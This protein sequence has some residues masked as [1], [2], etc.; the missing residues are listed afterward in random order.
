MSKTLIAHRLQL[1]KRCGVKRNCYLP[2][3]ATEI[4]NRP[5][6]KKETAAAHLD[7]SSQKGSDTVA[8]FKIV[9]KN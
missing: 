5:E 3:L 1:N 9:N 6:Q 8:Q 2:D 7:I 4:L